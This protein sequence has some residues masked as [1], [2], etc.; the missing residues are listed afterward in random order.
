MLIALVTVP[1]FGTLSNL[2]KGTSEV[3]KL[4]QRNRTE[5]DTD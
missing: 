2:M 1:G 4:K 3:L 5:N